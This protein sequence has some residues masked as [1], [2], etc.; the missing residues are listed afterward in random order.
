MSGEGKD[1]DYKPKKKINSTGVAEGRGLSRRQTRKVYYREVEVLSSGGESEETIVTESDFEGSIKTEREEAQLL[2]DTE[3]VV[4]RKKGNVEMA[5]EQETSK[6][7][8]LMEMLLESKIEDRRAEKRREEERRDLETRRQAERRELEIRREDERRELEERRREDDLRREE[9]IIRTLKETQTAVPQTVTIVNS[10]LPEMKQDEDID[11]Y[12]AMFEAALTASNTP[13]DQWKAKLHSHLNTRTKLRIHSTIQ[14]PDAT[15]DDI[16]EALLGCGTMTFSAAAETLLTGDRG[17]AYTLEHRQCKEKLVRITEKVMTVA[18]TVREAAQCVAVALMRQNLVPSLKTYIDLKGDFESEA[19][20]RTLDEWEATQ[21]VGTASF[22]KM[23]VPSSTSSMI[24]GKTPLGKKPISCYFCGKWGHISKDCRSRLSGDKPSTSQQ[25]VKLEPSGNEPYPQPSVTTT[26]GRMGKKEFTCFLC[27]QKGHKSPQCPQKQ[28][29]V[30]RVQIPSSKIVALRDNELFGSIG[31]HCMPITCDSGA[32]I[33]VVPEECV[34]SEQFTGGTC[35]VNSFNKVRST[36]RLCNIIVSI[37]GRQFHRKAVTQPGKDLAW[38]V[39]LSVPYSNKIEREFISGQMDAKFQLQEE[40]ICYLPPEMKDGILKSGLLVSEGT[41][42]VTKD[43]DD[44]PVDTSDTA[45]GEI[46]QIK[47]SNSLEVVEDVQSEAEVVS[48]GE[49]DEQKGE[50]EEFLVLEEKSSEA[51]EADGVQQ[52]GSADQGIENELSVESISSKEPITKLAESTKTD[53]TLTTVRTLADSQSQGYYWKDGLVFRTRLNRLGDSIEQMCLPKEYRGKCL[54]LAHENLGHMGRNKMGDH[55]RQYFY[56]P[57]ITADSM[58]HI[59]SCVPCQ[60]KD[61]TSPRRARMQEREI[62]TVPSERVA[63]DI[64]GP[65]P[66]AKGGFKYLLTY[67]D[68]ATRWPEAIPLKKT[69]TRIIIDQLTLIFS[70]CGF[71]T[72]LV[73]DNGPQFVART[74]TQ[75]LREKGIAHVRASPYHPQGNGVVERMHRTLKNV[76][77]RCTEK[78]GNWA[79]IVPMALYFLRSTPKSATGFSPFV[80]KHGWEPTT[81]L[82]LLYK[83]WV[84]SDLGPVDLEEWVMTNSERIERMREMAVATQKDI[85]SVRKKVWDKKAQNRQFEKGEQVYL[86]KSGLNTTLSDSWEGPYTVEKRNT[87][88]SYRINTGDRIIPSVHIQLLKMYKARQEEPRIRRVTSVLEPDTAEDQL[89]NQYAE[90]KVTGSVVHGDRERDIKCWEEEFKST[91]TKEPGLTNLVTFKM[92]TGTHAP[93]HQRPYNTPQSLVE[94]V[95]QELKWLLNK[96]YIRPSESPWA[97]P[98]VTVKKSDGTA[99]ICVDFKAINAVTEPI[100]FY[101]PRVE[102]VLESVGKAGVIS[103]LD[104]S[105]GYYQVPMSPADIPKTA[106]MCHQGRFE[107]VRMPFGVKNAPAVFQELMQKLFKDLAYC[108]TP[109]MDDLVIFSSTWEEHVQHVRLVLGKLRAAGLTANPAK[110]HWGGTKM[111]FLGHLVGEGTMSVPRHR[112]EA[113]ASFTKPTTKKGLRSFLG[114]IGFYRRYIE[115]LASQTAIL[116]PLT[117]KL[118]PSKIVW[119]EEGELAFSSICACISDCCSLCIPLPQDTFSIVTDASG[120]GV[121]GVLQVW[122][123][124]KWEAAAFFSRQIRG[125]EQRYSATELEALA[126]VCTIQHFSYYLYGRQFVAYT[127]HKPLV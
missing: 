87:P 83:G 106:F 109:Y 40:D 116:T 77:A 9:R 6:L 30:R 117:T 47:E 11:T 16:K 72:S 49:D 82:Q 31:N 121:G 62:V 74:F 43:S 99:R 21:P 64:V 19:F 59:R 65:F 91:L 105:K 96:G 28:N 26:P 51:G 60:K 107:F 61:V 100:P 41:V 42:I 53:D 37:A 86:R 67:L 108:C 84:Q 126:L 20:S 4:V 119:T 54:T 98:M 120:L 115:L 38:T 52:G 7:E 29:H 123:D 90:A 50:S 79:T 3:N 103:K 1:V 75:W 2:L 15:Y 68:M 35:E 58:A 24:Q 78:K 18:T 92:D 5:S 22:K 69:T 13:L 71:P 80:L 36:G 56:W 101:M 33:T 32:D 85:S 104:L 55:I 124:G 23:Y 97:S 44:K 95:N 45:A 66:V 17:K 118:A 127:D 10:K 89:D 113:L 73:S 46:K 125:A 8:R 34:E 93:I 48:D 102:E 57:S 25:S 63:I 39:C 94:S 76:I 14:N 114:A 12:I 70:R 88:L 27:H 81:P 110:C 122:R 111:E 112:V